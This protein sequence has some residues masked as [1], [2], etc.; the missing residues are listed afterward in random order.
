MGLGFATSNRGACHNKSCL[1]QNEL[2]GAEPIVDR[3]SPEGKAQLTVNRQDFLTAVDAAGICDFLFFGIPN[4]YFVDAL[5]VVTGEDYDMETVCK[6][7]ERI[8]NLEKL[9]NLRAGLTAKDDS[10]PPRFLN[11]TTSN[12]PSAG[13]VNHLP[14]MLSEY[15]T[16]RGWD[17]EGIPASTKLEELG[18]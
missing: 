3:H 10:L 18:L 7:G 2:L 8:W 6:T 13:K 9:F 1:H 17:K 12:G 16:I 4:E 14:E 15:Y 5:K 11:E